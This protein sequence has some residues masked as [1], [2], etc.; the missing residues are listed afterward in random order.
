MPI[1]LAKLANR[2]DPKNTVLFFGAGSS[3]PSGMLGGNPLR[4]ELCR[5][6]KVDRSY[7][8]TEA[9]Q[10]IEDSFSRRELIE[11]LRKLL[12]EKRPNG[13]LLNLPNYDWPSIFHDKL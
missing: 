8:L 6:F 5:H 11:Y 2:I 13:G 4:D 9:S 7:S 3:I 12:G 10:T 1:E